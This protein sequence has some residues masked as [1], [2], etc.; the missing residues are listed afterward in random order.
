MFQKVRRSCVFMLLFS[1]VCQDDVNNLTNLRRHTFNG[2][3]KRLY[4]TF[5]CSSK[6][7]NNQL[8]HKSVL[9]F[10]L[11]FCLSYFRNGILYV[12]K[13]RKLRYEIK[14]SFS[15]LATTCWESSK[16]VSSLSAHFA[17]FLSLAGW[18]QTNNGTHFWLFVSSFFLM[19]RKKSDETNKEA[20]S[21]CLSTPYDSQ[22]GY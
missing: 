7:R 16:W 4:L 9:Y 2:P 18:S 10:S 14:S 8:S 1:L 22:I 15:A 6:Q 13:V 21:E 12:E 17:I 3:K 11:S 20:K 5:S 19:R